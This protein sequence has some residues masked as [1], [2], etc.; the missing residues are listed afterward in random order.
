MLALAAHGALALD[1]T[2]GKTLYRECTQLRA[3]VNELRFNHADG[4]ARVRYDALSAALQQQYFGA[5]KI[6]SFHE[7][8]RAAAEAAVAQRERDRVA[9]EIAAKQQ[10]DRNVEKERAFAE[11][12]QRTAAAAEAQRVE[13]AEREKEAESREWWGAFRRN[14]WIALCIIV[15]LVIYFLPTV[16]AVSRKKLNTGAIFALNFFLGWSLVGWV[17]ALT[18]A[19]TVDAAAL[20]A[21]KDQA[22]ARRHRELMHHQTRL[23]AA[24]IAAQQQQPRIAAPVPK[25]IRGPEPPPAR[26]A[27]GN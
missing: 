5:Q 24:T 19:L 10:Q 13:K 6:A 7:Q 26:R 3:E 14:T 27:D 17:V 12:R 1:I 9:A 16:I 22:E 4:T 18:W 23:A 20:L 15:S 2:A 25:V 21:A 11:S 8:E